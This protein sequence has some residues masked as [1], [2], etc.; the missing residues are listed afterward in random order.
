MAHPGPASR[1]E[2]RPS[3]QTES[4]SGQVLPA[5]SSENMAPPFQAMTQPRIQKMPDPAQG[6]ENLTPAQPAMLGRAGECEGTELIQRLLRLRSPP[7]HLQVRHA[8]RR[9]MH[10]AADRGLL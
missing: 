10:N 2:H 4:S 1:Q 9:S 7:V 6:K 3:M 8:L 5:P